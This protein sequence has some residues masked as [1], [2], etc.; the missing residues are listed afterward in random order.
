M[1]HE[2]D[3]AKMGRYIRMGEQIC[4]DVKSPYVRDATATLVDELKKLRN[5]YA[6][7]LGNDS[8]SSLQE[9]H[10]LEFTEARIEALVCR[11]S[12]DENI[13]RQLVS[14]PEILIYAA[15]ELTQ[16][17]FVEG[18]EGEHSLP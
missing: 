17:K 13:A 2:P 1:A 14:R 8:A 18:K 6:G 11:L 10:E 12:L 5:M 9:C 3:L 4:K 16:R 15:I 7:I